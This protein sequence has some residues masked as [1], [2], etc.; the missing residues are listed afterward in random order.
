[1]KTYPAALAVLTLTGFASLAAVAAEKELSAGQ[2]PQAVHEA[3]QKAYPAAKKAKYSEKTKDGKIVYEVEFKEGGR[4]LEATY[5]AEGALME[6][7]E[8]IK[9]T[10]LP[11][12]VVNAVKKAHPQAELKEAEKVFKPDGTLSGYEV[13]VTDGKKKLELDLDAAGTILKTE[14]EQD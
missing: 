3:F 8:E 1:M 2:I 13:E 7:E 9:T 4:E 14:E 11:E 5:G 10:E 12:T 6:V